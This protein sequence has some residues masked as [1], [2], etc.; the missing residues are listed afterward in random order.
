MTFFCYYMYSEGEYYMLDK[1]WNLIKKLV[2]KIATYILK[3]ISNKINFVKMRFKNYIDNYII[4]K[5]RIFRSA[6][7]HKKLIL[8]LILVLFVFTSGSALYIFMPNIK[9]H[10][11]ADNNSLSFVEYNINNN[12]ETANENKTSV[13]NNNNNLAT[14]VSNNVPIDNSY[15]WPTNG[16]YYISTYFSYG[17]DGIDIAGIG[18]NSNIYTVFSGQVVTASYTSANGNYIIVKNDDGKYAMYAHLTSIYVYNGQR[19]D[20]GVVIGG[21]GATGRATGVHLH[22]SIWTGYPYY[23]GT[24]LNPYNFY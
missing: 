5:F 6:I 9:N 23:G 18:Y 11:K 20:K 15:C 14:P 8:R 7:K 16:N 17:H 19:V 2:R 22:F 3:I 21:A 4:K 13:D 12:N 24:A 10:F 1:L